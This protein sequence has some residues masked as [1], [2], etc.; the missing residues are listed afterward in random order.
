[1]GRGE[2]ALVA[3]APLGR[4]PNGANPN[5]GGKCH[6]NRPKKVATIDRRNL[7]ARKALRSFLKKS[8]N[9]PPVL[10]PMLRQ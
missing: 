1:M 6:M 3:L 10:P 4:P 5:A 7:L 2:G 8:G 9:R